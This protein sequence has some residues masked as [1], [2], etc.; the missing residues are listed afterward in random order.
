MQLNIS[1]SEV[2]TPVF[3]KMNNYVANNTSLIWHC[4]SLS[5]TQARP[6][7]NANTHLTHIRYAHYLTG[8]RRLTCRKRGRSRKPSRSLPFHATQFD[9]T[10]D[11][12]LLAQITPKYFRRY[13]PD[14]IS[15]LVSSWLGLPLSHTKWTM[16]LSFSRRLNHTG[17]CLS[18]Q[19]MDFRFVQ[20]KS[21]RLIGEMIAVPTLTYAFGIGR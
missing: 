17:V 16:W 2:P 6:V 11:R 3:D 15:Q 20:L 4:T 13:F 8:G 14:F 21:Q 9:I 19:K 5:Q 18:L 10:R 12:A 7:I 1:C